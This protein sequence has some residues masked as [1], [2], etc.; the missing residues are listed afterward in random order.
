MTKMGLLL[1]KMGRDMMKE[2]I[3]L[4]KIKNKMAKFNINFTINMDIK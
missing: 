1:G 4:S 2:D 3:K